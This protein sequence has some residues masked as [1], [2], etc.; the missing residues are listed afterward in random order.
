MKNEND[1]EE[2]EEIEKEE[3]NNQSFVWNHQ[4]TKYHHY[5]HQHHQSTVGKLSYKAYCIFVVPDRY[6][7]QKQTNVTENSLN[8]NCDSLSLFV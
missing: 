2:G 1:G 7:E 5:H 4:P 6:L 8:A 3:K